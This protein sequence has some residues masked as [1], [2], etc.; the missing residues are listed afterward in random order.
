MRHFGW[1]ALDLP[2]GNSYSPFLVAYAQKSFLA[3]MWRARVAELADALDLGSSGQPWGFESP[4]S[5]QNVERESSQSVNMNQ[6]EERLIDRSLL[7]R[8]G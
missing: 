2:L 6:I 7:V 4:L 5:H 8:N 3:M 1:I